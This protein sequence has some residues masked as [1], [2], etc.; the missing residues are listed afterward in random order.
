MRQLS[1]SDRD[2]KGV[3]DANLTVVAIFPDFSQQVEEEHE[4]M[5]YAT[6]A[7]VEATLASMAGVKRGLCNQRR[8]R[9]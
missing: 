6:Q 8:A 1:I 7:T 9:A 2:R 5:R 3:I 4:I